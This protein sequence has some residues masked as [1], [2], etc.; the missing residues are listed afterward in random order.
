M[1]T[2]SLR[3]RT[4]SLYAGLLSLANAIDRYGNAFAGL[5]VLSLAAPTQSFVLRT[6]GSR[7]RFARPYE[8]SI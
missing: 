8:C 5:R 1:N 4:I 3:F 6:D 7:E 2:K